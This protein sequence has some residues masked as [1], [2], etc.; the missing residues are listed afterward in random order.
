M[1]QV[2]MEI[3]SGR[4]RIVRRMFEHLDYKVLRLDRVYYAG[5][6][7][8]GLS[9]GRW[10]H[11]SQNEVYMLKMSTPRKKQGKKPERL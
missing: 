2:G 3:H 6:T 9:K 10:R 11:L 8:K 1:R 4:N 5:L 7:K